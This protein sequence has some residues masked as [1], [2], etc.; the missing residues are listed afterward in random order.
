[1]YKGESYVFP[2]TLLKMRPVVEKGLLS[3]FSLVV[4]DFS[5]C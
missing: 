2:I 3:S 4:L 1:M 5:M